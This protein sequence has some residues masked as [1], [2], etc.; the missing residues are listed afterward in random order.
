MN[1]NNDFM[2]LLDRLALLQSESVEDQKE[3]ELQEAK[4]AAKKAEAAKFLKET[5]G[6]TATVYMNKNAYFMSGEAAYLC[7]LKL[8]SV[9]NGAEGFLASKVNREFTTWLYGAQGFMSNPKH[10]GGSFKFEYF[11]P[12]AIFDDEDS[13]AIG[14]IDAII[15]E[16]GING[17]WFLKEGEQP[18]FIAQG[19]PEPTGYT[20]KQEILIKVRM[21]AKCI[22]SDAKPWNPRNSN[23]LNSGKSVEELNALF[24]QCDQVR[25]EKET[26]GLQAWKA[27]NATN[28]LVNDALQDAATGLPTTEKAPRKTRVKAV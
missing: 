15:K 14:L 24:D 28:A 6:F 9:E 10:Q 8:T 11:L 17:R 1:R 16:D 21:D 26:K 23:P 4:K 7:K 19:Q 2:G 22:L 27:T 12:S 20:A 13:D 18:I 25:V 5:P 3:Q